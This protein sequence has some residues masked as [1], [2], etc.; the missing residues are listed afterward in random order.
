MSRQLYNEMNVEIPY[1]ESRTK[2]T[3][4]IFMSDQMRYLCLVEEIDGQVIG[5]IAGTVSQPMFSDV[6]VA[7]EPF[8]FVNPYRRSEG[9]G[10]DLIEAYYYWA[11]LLGCKYAT[12]SKPIHAGKINPIIGQ[13]TETSYL[14]AL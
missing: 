5:A 12:I 11:K 9:Y 6:L 3:F 14:K 13:A 4:K 1:S 10:K 2:E 8:L 7:V